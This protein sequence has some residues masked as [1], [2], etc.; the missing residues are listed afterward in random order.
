MK[1]FTKAIE[2]QLR[3]NAAESEAA[4]LKDGNTPN[5]KPVVK[6]FNP[7]GAATWLFTELHTDGRL[8]GLCDLGMGEPE[9][10]YADLNELMAVKTRPFGLPLERDLHFTAKMTLKEYAEKAQAEGRLTA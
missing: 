7:Y 9:L 5:H 3:K 6:I 8:F 4:I 2:A 10:G 1:F